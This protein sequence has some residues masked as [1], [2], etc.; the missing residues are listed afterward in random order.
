MRFLFPLLF[1][2]GL[3]LALNSPAQ[4]VS[5]QQQRYIGSPFSTGY[6]NY[7]SQI[8]AEPSGN[9][10]A[11]GLFTGVVDFDG[12]PYVA[13]GSTDGY[14]V[15]YNAS[16]ALQW[17]RVLSDPGSGAYSINGLCVLPTGGIAIIGIARDSTLLDGNP[18]P[19]PP[20]SGGTFTA[21][22]DTAGALQWIDVTTVDDMVAGGSQ[23]RGIAADGSGRLYVMGEMF[24]TTRTF[25]NNITIPFAPNVS[26]ITPYVACYSPAGQLQW[27]KA[28][29]QRLQYAYPAGITAT[30]NGC[31]VTAQYRASL[32]GIILG[33]PVS[34][35]LNIYDYDAV[36][37]ALDSSGNTLWGSSIKNPNDDFLL[38]TPPVSIGNQVAVAGS[39]DETTTFGGTAVTFSGSGQQFRTFIATYN[40]ADGAVNTVQ[41]VAE[42]LPSPSNR[43]RAVP[44]TL[45]INPSGLY[46]AGYFTGRMQLPGQP[47]LEATAPG[48]NDG[49]VAKYDVSGTTCEWIATARNAPGSTNYS[50]VE[51]TAAAVLPSGTVVAGGNFGSYG[52]TVTLGNTTF[53][54]GNTG[55]SFIGQITAVLGLPED[56]TTAAPA[57]VA[58]PNPAREQ[59]QLRLPTGTP[60][61]TAR[62]LDA[63]GREVRTLA[64]NGPTTLDVRG[65]PAGVYLLRVAAGPRVF[66]RRLVVQP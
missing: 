8:A 13:Q 49:F 6:Y 22:L 29:A 44:T 37:V 41:V 28:T 59:V 51:I 11:C 53:T 15:K 3:L 39:A 31:V 14:V 62:L 30:A 23:P 10:Y 7:L 40:A 24:A 64:V 42:P 36:V 66:T 48:V 60:L 46:L 61:G 47:L 17:V 57:L 35:T 1:S 19:F 25:S 12:I 43:N 56:P 16:G 4:T 52:S 58:W 18:V 38:L 20:N 26:G 54:A 5:W 55:D 63:L 34:R 50:F 2:V 45:H 32:T 9:Y 27:A 33:Y 21:V 65:L